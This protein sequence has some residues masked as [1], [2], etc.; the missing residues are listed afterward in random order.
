M[1]NNTNT[2]QEENSLWFWKSL[3]QTICSTT[4]IHALL[5]VPERH[6]TCDSV[7]FERCW[8]CV[9]GKLQMT[10]GFGWSSWPDRGSSPQRVWTQ[11]AHRA[12]RS[13]RR[14]WSEPCSNPWTTDP[15]PR[16]C[17][18]SEPLH[19]W[20]EPQK[21]AHTHTHTHGFSSDRADFC[22]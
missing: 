18:P 5:S 21:P 11:R 1:F 2:F 19:Y 4:L 14:R 22:W 6:M 7:G 10:A 3:I 8:W 12:A 13:L 17:P 15:E 20:P 16:W 9:P